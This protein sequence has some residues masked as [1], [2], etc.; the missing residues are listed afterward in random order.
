M[1]LPNKKSLVF[2]GLTGFVCLGMIASEPIRQEKPVYTNLK[3]LSKSMDEEKMETVMHSFNSQLGVTCI[4]CHI[5]DKSSPPEA[6]FATD[7]KPEKLIARKMLEM[8]I[9]LNRKYFGSQIDGNLD[10]PGKIWCETC[11]H[12]IPRPE[13]PHKKAVN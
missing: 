9:K 13:L 2:F 3:V 12:G 1:I 8:T 10:K 11:H 5:Q 7:V 6:D 4:Y